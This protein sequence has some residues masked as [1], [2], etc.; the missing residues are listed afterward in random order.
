MVV[1]YKNDD[2]DIIDNDEY[3]IEGYCEKQTWNHTEENCP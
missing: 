3:N 1:E 2:I